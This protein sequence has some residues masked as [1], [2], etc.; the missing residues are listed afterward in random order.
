MPFGKYKVGD[1]IADAEDMANAL[2]NRPNNVVAVKAKKPTKP[3]DTAEK[4]AKSEEVKAEA[5]SENSISK[6][7]KE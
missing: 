4:A 5:A 1:V 2:A 6:D 7:S 3:V